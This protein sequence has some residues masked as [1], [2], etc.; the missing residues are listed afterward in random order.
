MLECLRT[1]TVL[2]LFSHMLSFVTVSWHSGQLSATAH[3]CISFQVHLLCMAIKQLEW[4]GLY[5]KNASS[6]VTGF[7]GVTL[8]HVSWVASGNSS[9]DS[10]LAPTQFAC[11][12]SRSLSSACPSLFYIPTI[13]PETAGIYSKLT[14]CLQSLA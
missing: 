10:A 4:P 9:E 6:V 13:I 3:T 1:L 8:G 11:L 2:A 5:P 7:A 12:L 14:S